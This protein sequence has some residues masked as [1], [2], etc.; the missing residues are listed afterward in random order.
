MPRVEIPIVDLERGG[1][2]TGSQVDADMT[3]NHVIH[4]MQSGM[5]IEIES[6]DGSDQI[7]TVH[8]APD[9]LAD[10]L[11]VDPFPITVPAGETVW[12]APFKVATFRQNADRDMYLDVPVDTTLKFRV[13]R[14]PSVAE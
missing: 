6:S 11:T 13:G 3:N 2:S 5:F 1:V 7:V 10:G 4:G 9:F 12:C 8:S 14:V